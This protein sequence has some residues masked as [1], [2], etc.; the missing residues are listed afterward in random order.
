M[1]RK[2]KVVF[3]GT[4]DFA[5]PSLNALKEA[6]YEVPLVITQPDRPAGR[7]KKLTP[8]PVKVLAEELGIPVYQPEKVKGNRELLETLRKINPDLIVV[9]AYGKILPDEILNL[10][11]FGCI[12]VHAS[13]LPE[14]RGASPIQSVLLDGK[15]ETGVTIM[16]ISPELDAG[17]IIS[18][19]KVKIEK[20]DN[21][22]TLHDKLAKVG[23]ELLVET[24]PDYV[25]GKIT[26]VPQDHSKATY[27]KPIKK[28]MGR[29]DWTLPA[30][31]IFNMVRAFTPWPSAYAEFKGRRVKI[32]EAEPV[33]LQ[34]KPG[35]V[36]KAD[37]ELVVATGE[38]ALRIKRI[39]PEGRKEITGEEFIRGYRVKVGDM[40]S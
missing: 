5:V 19:R 2:L 18:Q 6:G 28:E 37:K 30:E 22:Q 15:E 24:I 40:F 29:I 17:D 13:L 38:G 35:E 34:G 9:A 1:E 21:A 12:N 14:Y 27:C 20:S 33:N 4:P 3:M 36:V 7:G 11:K 31:R 23:A 26:P 39:R 10:P 25:S 8:P 16:K 32:T